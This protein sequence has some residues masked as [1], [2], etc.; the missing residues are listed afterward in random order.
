MRVSGRV[1]DEGPQLDKGNLSETAVC[2]KFISPALTAA[3]WD[4]Y[5]QILRE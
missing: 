2:E 1:S 5:A 3:G 4:V